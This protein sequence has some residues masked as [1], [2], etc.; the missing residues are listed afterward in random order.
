MV[1]IYTLKCQAPREDVL[2]TLLVESEYLINDRLITTD[3]EEQND[4]EAFDSQSHSSRMQQKPTE[5][6]P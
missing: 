1:L 6:H 4:P 3:F 5:I 2:T